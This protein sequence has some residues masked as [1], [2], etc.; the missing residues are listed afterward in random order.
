MSAEPDTQEDPE[1]VAT[2]DDIRNYI[3]SSITFLGDPAQGIDATEAEAD[4]L[5]VNQDIHQERKAAIVVEIPD[6]SREIVQSSEVAM[7]V[8]LEGETSQDPAQFRETDPEEMIEEKRE[9][10]RAG[11]REDNQDLLLQEAET[12]TTERE[13][14]TAAP[15]EPNR[16]ENQETHLRYVC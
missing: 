2:V 15:Q 3:N 1:A 11:M 8:P 14:L 7:V 4:L 10:M 6:I 12:E 16:D 5:D 9:G 13:S